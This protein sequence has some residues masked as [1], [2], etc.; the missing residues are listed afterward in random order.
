MKSSLL[1]IGGL[2]AIA[3]GLATLSFSAVAAAASFSISDSGPGSVNVI[4]V[5]SGYHCYWVGS[6]RHPRYI[7]CPVVSFSNVSDSIS[8][9]GPGSVNIIRLN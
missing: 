8:D 2:L 4:S 6:Q 5:D 9:S 3:L 1:R 7:C